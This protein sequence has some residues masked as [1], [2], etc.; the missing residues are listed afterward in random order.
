MAWA[1]QANASV[2][3]EGILLL[4]EVAVLC[5]RVE[6][7]QIMLAFVFL[8]A[9]LALESSWEGQMLNVRKMFAIS[10]L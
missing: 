3:S 4:R 5:G 9:F 1:R 6:M 2:I 7:K 8:K 10:D